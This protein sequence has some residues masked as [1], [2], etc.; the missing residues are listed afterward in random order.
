M[1]L[2]TARAIDGDWLST[3]I[4]FLDSD[5]HPYRREHIELPDTHP[6]SIDVY[7]RTVTALTTDAAQPPTL[8]QGIRWTTLDYVLLG[9]IA[10]Q[11]APTLPTTHG[12]LYDQALE[13][14]QN[15][16]ATV[17][18]RLA[19]REPDRALLRKA[20]ACV[21]LVSAPE[22]NAY[23]ILTAVEELADNAAERLA[24][25]RTL[26]TCLC[27]VPG[28]G[29]ALRP[30]PVGDHLLLRELGAD[31]G[32][33]LR[34]LD[35]AG[36]PGLERALIILVRAGQND[37]KTAT[38]LITTLLDANVTR[39]PYVLT[40]AF[41]QGGAATSSLEELATR[42]ETP[43]PLDELSAALPFSSLSLYRLALIIDQ[44]RL[45]AARAAGREPAT[46]AELLQRVGTR[47]SDAGDR[48]GALVSIT[49]AVDSYRQLAG[50]NPAAFLPGLAMSLHN[51]SNRQ[52]EIGQADA[53]ASSW[54]AAIDA[55]AHPA[56]RA[57]LR[58]AWARRLSAS[59]HPE[60]AWG[61]LR[62]AA[63]E[64]DLPTAGDGPPDR[65][66]AILMSRAR[67]AIRSLVQDL[68]STGAADGLP[69]WASAPLLDSQI[70]LV[71]AY[72]QA[73]GWPA[74]QAVLEEH[75]D[76][77]TSPEFRT[78][79]HALAG[80]Y[81]TDSV[82]GDLLRLLDEIDELGIE[83]V[84]GRRNADY[85]R[86]ALLA[87]WV[88]TPTW[89]ESF[90]FFRANQAA[91]ATDDSRAFLDGIDHNLARRHL[92]ILVLAGV[93]PVEQVYAVVKD[94]AV[95]EEAVF[96]AIEAGNL[97]VLS[98]ILAAAPELQ[99]RPNAWGLAVSV[100]LLAQ[101]EPDQAHQ[102]GRQVAEQAT[103]IQRRA[104]AIRLRAL[105]S[106]HPD[107]PGLDDLIQIIELEIP[108]VVEGA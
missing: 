106:Q 80:L 53:A 69:V 29:L 57:G 7:H 76:C 11:G 5:A 46:L 90:D 64:A 47:A 24:T 59:E 12:E 50:A 6:D 83:K 44:R 42:P 71:V 97:P 101:E 87:A 65:T 41:T 37:P 33:L 1:V 73:D 19:S 70:E 105:R 100:L 89:S 22:N 40:I 104:H 91:L 88:N 25:R 52:S 55:I 99:T 10:A 108:P 51:L 86:R 93:L 61:Q 21:S 72:D 92:G 39:W 16:W 20:A 28:E 81:P 103:A 56:A 68:G 77:L 32:L 43:L 107:L 45:A 23:R 3:I 8:P 102:L 66:S 79:V 9:W 95:A 18:R 63:A 60:Q 35:A 58:V 62:T 31:E 96:A 94:T 26:V 78:A 67:I 15:Y 13:H 14:E 82:P 34:T 2:L 48:A 74:T 27:P 54:H 75:R 4:E 84:F 49:E 98:A 85:D 17:Y 30:D 36:Q 38:R